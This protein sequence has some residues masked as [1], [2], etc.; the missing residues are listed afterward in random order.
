VDR[1]E[2]V[3]RAKRAFRFLQ[4]ILAGQGPKRYSLPPAL[5]EEL[6]DSLA[7]A[8]LLPSASCYILSMDLRYGCIKDRDTPD[9]SIEFSFLQSNL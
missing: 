8:S 2:V 7:G 4:Y 3:A 6:S 9:L 1:E 5:S